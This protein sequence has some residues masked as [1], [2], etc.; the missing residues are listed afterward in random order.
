MPNVSKD[1]LPQLD[2]LRAVAVFLVVGNHMT[3][4]LPE[5]NFYVNKITAFWFRG[6]WVGVDLFFVLSGF[7]VSGLLFRE[8]QEKKNLNI[9][10]FLVRRGFKI[11]PAFWVLIALTCLV[12]LFINI[13]F[14]RLGLFGELAFVQNYLGNLWDHTWTLA[15]EEHFYIGLC[16]LFYLLLKDKKSELRNPF[17]GILRIFVIIAV[18]CFIMRL[19]TEISLPFEYERNI[20]P[21]HLRVDSLFFGV[22]ISYFWHFRDLSENEFLN[23]NKFLIGILGLTLLLPAFIFE[24]DKNPWIGV[25]GLPMFYLGSGCLL[26]FFLKSDFSKVPLAKFAAYL[27]TFSYSIYLWNMPVQ[28]WLTKAVAN[29]TGIE[30]WFFYFAIYILGTFLIGIGMSKIIEY[31]FLKLRNRYFP[32]LSPPLTQTIKN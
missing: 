14:Y 26:L 8:Y 19:M 4:C 22:L 25:I 31:P 28:K 23:R 24:L 29:Q 12:G 15:V 11:Y 16:L 3:I 30:N 5:T 32:T 10:R 9:K 17:T 27:G 7:L 18:G 20:E 2:I 6:G 13:N 21:T 1:R